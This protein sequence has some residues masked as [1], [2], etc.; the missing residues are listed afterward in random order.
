MPRRRH[1]RRLRRR[2]KGG[3]LS[4]IRRA[5]RRTVRP[6]VKY[7][8]TSTAGSL[9]VTAGFTVSIANV[10]QGTTDITRL[11]DSIVVRAIG[12]RWTI[13]HPTAATPPITQQI[14]VSIIQDTL[15][16]TSAGPTF[17][18]VYGAAVSAGFANANFKDITNNPGSRYKV[19]W[20]RYFP[21]KQ[22]AIGAIA[23]STAVNSVTIQK[24]IR[25]KRPVVIHYTGAAGTTWTQNSLFVIGASN[26][27]TAAGAAGI[28]G[29]T[30]IR[31][32]DS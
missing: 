31:F 5:I 2:R 8:D 29:V 17:A 21:L 4:L 1:T 11:G 25:L 26:V 15:N 32:T 12:I 3:L 22:I 24:Y 28:A 27:T 14:R 30:R 13:Q 6:E 9:D 20:E 7:F 18:N 16:T 23:G 10:A 19:L